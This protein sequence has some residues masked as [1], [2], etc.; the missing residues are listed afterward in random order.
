MYSSTMS[1]K[2][3]LEDVDSFEKT[4]KSNDLAY[5]IPQPFT[6][7]P[8]HGEHKKA[9]SSVSF[10][11]C[12]NPDISIINNGTKTTVE[13]TSST[14]IPKSNSLAL[15]ASASA[16]A[17]VKVWDIT[18]SMISNLSSSSVGEEEEH[19][20]NSQLMKPI[21]CLYGHTRGINDVVWSRTSSYIATASD[22]KTL[23][24][25]DVETSDTLVE[26]KGHTNFVFSTKFSP[27]SS[28]LLV[29]GSFDETVRLWDVRSGKCVMT[30][31][32]HS[33]PVTAV[34]FNRDGTCIVSASH[35]GLIRI[36]DT[37]TGECFKTIYADGNPPASFCKFSPNGK[38]VLAGTLDDKMRLWRISSKTATT[39]SASSSLSKTIDNVSIDSMYNDFNKRLYSKTTNNTSG[40][41]RCTK[42]YHGSHEN[43]KFCIFSSFL[44]S[45]RKRQC[46]VTGSEDN[47]IY[48]YNLQNSSGNNNNSSSKVLHQTLKGHTD[49]VLA[50]A[51]HPKMEL[52]A[53]GGMTKD[54]TVRFWAPSCPPQTMET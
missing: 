11:P 37:A 16:D 53:S 9:V 5:G 8:F 47:N 26:F 13:E 35:D 20:K 51:T 42:V 19:F 24:L 14:S 25:W 23:R 43:K 12:S 32:A 18:H 15:C 22:D 21:Q 41:S 52:L 17:S 45:N 28:N 30:I 44:V 4:V 1:N 54:K 46:V 27:Q 29:S 34:D 10:A 39:T 2:R 33:D 6:N 49:S 38:Y 31:P 50:V 40:S 48:L 7:I 36:W 3:K